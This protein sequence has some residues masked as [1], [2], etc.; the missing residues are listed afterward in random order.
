MA[1]IITHLVL[2]H[3]LKGLLKVSNEREY[4]L[5]TAFPDIR[6]LAGLSRDSTH[7]NRLTWSEVLAKDSFQTGYNLHSWVDRAHFIF[8]SESKISEAMSSTQ[9][10]ALKFSEDTLLYEKISAPEWKKIAEYFDIITDAELAFGASKDMVLK[11][12]RLVQQALINGPTAEVLKASL[13]SLDL[14]KQI[15]NFQKTV[16][17]AS[18]NPTVKKV[19]LSFYDQIETLTQRI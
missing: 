9:N 8:M 16:F 2:A 5:G 1:A 17:E 11:W 7:Q 19:T 12:H 3:K 6:Y 15:D 4:Y 18:Q 14:T 13:L 10:A